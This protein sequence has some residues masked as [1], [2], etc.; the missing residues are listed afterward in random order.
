V[1]HWFKIKRGHWDPFKNVG[2]RSGAQLVNSVFFFLSWFLTIPLENQGR[3][4]LTN[5]NRSKVCHFFCS[6]ANMCRSTC[7]WKTLW[8]IVVEFDP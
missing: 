2:W 6:L 7:Y 4:F 3:S 5:V 8:W 1:V